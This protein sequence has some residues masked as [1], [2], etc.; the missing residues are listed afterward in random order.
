[1]TNFL[2]RPIGRFLLLCIA[3]PLARTLAYSTPPGLTTIT[4]AVYLA[5]GQLAG[6]TIVFT[7]PTAIRKLAA[8]LRSRTCIVLR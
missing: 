8:D 7:W 4:D 5:N 6:G 2:S 3:F 1:M